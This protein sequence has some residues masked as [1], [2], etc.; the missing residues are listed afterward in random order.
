MSRVI[1]GLVAFSLASAAGFAQTQIFTTQTPDGVV[2]TGTSIGQPGIPQMPARD[3]QP[4]RTGTSRIRGRVLAGETGQPVN[5]ANVRLNSPE[6]REGK[7]TS[8]DQDGRYEFR[9]LPS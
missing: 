2:V 6:L 5:R 8:T 3:T 7:G 1:A 9:D 4:P